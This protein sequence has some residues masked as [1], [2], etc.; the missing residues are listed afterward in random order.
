MI[1]NLLLYR[2]IDSFLK[3]SDRYQGGQCWPATATGRT[4]GNGHR[5]PLDR[6]RIRASNR[7]DIW[8]I[9]IVCC[10]PFLLLSNARSCRIRLYDDSRVRPFAWLKPEKMKTSVRVV[11]TRKK[12]KERKNTHIYTYI[13]KREIIKGYKS[14]FRIP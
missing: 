12:K 7:A 3:E 5:F 13:Y 2:A 6:A 11:D 14:L 8:P 10:P 1:G 9:P 4:K